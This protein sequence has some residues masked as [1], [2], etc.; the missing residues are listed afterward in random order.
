MEDGKVK[1]DFGRMVEIDGSGNEIQI[2]RAD[3]SAGKFRL[4][5]FFTRKCL[6]GTVLVVLYND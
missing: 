4:N 5:Y 2:N 3:L 6:H 1:I